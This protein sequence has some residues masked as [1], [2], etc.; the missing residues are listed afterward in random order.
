MKKEADKLL[1]TGAVGSGESA[2][3]SES[4]MPVKQEKE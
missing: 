4:G 3:G 2:D 1:A